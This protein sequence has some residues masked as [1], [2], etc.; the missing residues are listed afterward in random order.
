MPDNSSIHPSH[1]DH[2]GSTPSRDVSLTPRD[3]ECENLSD[4]L[5]RDAKSYLVIPSPW[6]AARTTTLALDTQQKRSFWAGI[7]QLI[8]WWMPIPLA[9][10]AALALFLP[11]QPTIHSHSLLSSSENEFEEHMEMIASSDSFQ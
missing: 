6:F 8:R 11:Q 4:L 7:P 1:S 10:V 3:H 5:D 2:L 9:G